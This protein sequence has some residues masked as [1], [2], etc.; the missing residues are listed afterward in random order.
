[1]KSLCFPEAKGKG[2]GISGLMTHSDYQIPELA[3]SARAGDRTSLERLVNLFHGD[4][5]RMVFY[6]TC[7]R[8]DAEDLTQE[9]FMQMMKSLPNLKD[10]SRFRPWLFRIAINRVRD[11]HRKKSILNFFGTSS[12]VEDSVHISPVNSDDPADRLIQKEF[13]KQFHEFAKCLSQ[14]EREVFILRFADH[15]GIREIAETLKKNESTVKTHL[16]RALKKLRKTPGLRDM[17]Q[18]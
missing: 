18:S 1:M 15:L 11:F 5:F 17:L 16:Y 6:R 2:G 8:M 7:S 9:I 4:I 13:W 10:T 14:G 3:E 12:E